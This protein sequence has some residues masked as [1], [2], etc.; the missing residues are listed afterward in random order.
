MESEIK[1]GLGLLGVTSL[2]ELD[3]SCLQPA[4]PV[5]SPHVF[6]AFPLLEIAPY[7]Y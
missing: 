6:S 3:R 1:I 2:S 4:T 5:N 7:K